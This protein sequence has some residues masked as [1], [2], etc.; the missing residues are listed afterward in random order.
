MVIRV[1]N[2]EHTPTPLKRGRLPHYTGC[3]RWDGGITKV[4]ARDIE[5]RQGLQTPV[6][7]EHSI[8][9]PA[10]V[11]DENMLIFCNPCGVGWCCSSNTGV[12]LRSPLPIVCKSWRTG[13]TY[14]VFYIPLPLW[15]FNTNYRVMTKNDCLIVWL[16]DCLSILTA[17]ATQALT[18]SSIQAIILIVWVYWLKHLHNQAFKQLFNMNC[19]A[20]TINSW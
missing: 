13:E 4:P 20:M 19:H 8:P 18:Q 1:L 5:Y 9:N 14:T 17:S 12:T 2:N 10:G 6:K 7:K 16:L 3:N 11:A 15:W